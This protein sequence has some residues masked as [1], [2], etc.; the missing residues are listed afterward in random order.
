MRERNDERIKRKKWKRRKENIDRVE[1]KIS[2]SHL[3][4]LQDHLSVKDDKEREDDQPSILSNPKLRWW[5]ID[6]KLG[7]QL[8]VEQ[9][10]APH[11][12]IQ[13]RGH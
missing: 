13:Q 7:N 2:I 1:N 10:L 9:K 8:D 4:L 12:D 6:E 11:E 5:E 3:E